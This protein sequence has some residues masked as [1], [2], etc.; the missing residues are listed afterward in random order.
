M[1][2]ACVF[3]R[4][5]SGFSEVIVSMNGAESTSWRALREVV[6]SL[7]ESLEPAPASGPASDGP[8]ISA[9][10]SCWVRDE[11]NDAAEIRQVSLR[12]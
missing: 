4:H 1:R 2:S 5:R 7:I 8:G 10:Q 9:P 12:W 6:G 11:K 3:P